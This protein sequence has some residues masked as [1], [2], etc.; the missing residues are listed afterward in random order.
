M[1][2]S[3][4]SL[5]LPWLSRDPGR[6]LGDLGKKSKTSVVSILAHGKLL[7]LDDITLLKPQRF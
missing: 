3:R 7:A 1:S 4:I 6:G 2:E 5:W